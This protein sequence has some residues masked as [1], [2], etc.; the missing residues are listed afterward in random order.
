MAR[1]LTR[2][3][4]TAIRPRLKSTAATLH[5]CARVAASPLSRICGR[6]CGRAAIL[7]P[8]SVVP[9]PGSAPTAAPLAHCNLASGDVVAIVPPLL[10]DLYP[11]PVSCH[12]RLR[13]HPPPL[14]GAASLLQF[15]DGKSILNPL[16]YQPVS[17][18]HPQ[19]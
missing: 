14:S 9:R 3:A 10:I 5:C 17:N 18:L 6:G 7:P 4:C 8:S 15:L 11:C 19:L 13:L 2:V 12:R 1:S 16:N